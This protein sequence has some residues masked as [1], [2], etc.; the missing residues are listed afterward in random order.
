M[1]GANL[2]KIPHRTAKP[3]KQ[4]MLVLPALEAE[5]VLFF[6]PQAF[7]HFE[8][9]WAEGEVGRPVVLPRSVKAGELRAPGMW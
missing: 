8:S 5:Q 1:T 3:S 6:T 4:G 9:R 7:A 2:S